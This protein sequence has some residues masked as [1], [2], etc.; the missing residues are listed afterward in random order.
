MLVLAVVI[1]AAGIRLKTGIPGLR[2]VHR[3]AASLE[4]VVVLWLAWMA[5]RRPAVLLALALT[6]I[7]SIVGIIGGQEPPRAIA[8]VNLLGGLSLASVFAWMLAEKGSGPFSEKRVLTPFLVLLVFQILL[9]AWLT[10][11]QRTGAVL[12]AHGLFAMVLMALV[13]FLGLRKRLPLAALVT[14]LA[15]FTALHYEYSPAAALV[16]AVAAAL[17][18]AVSAY[19][20]SRG[21]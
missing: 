18:V 13:I 19:T 1:A 12:P 9:G 11:V 15:G 7:L 4:V 21:A 16:H 17:L 2:I 20:L 6:A 5:W 10:I 14:V 8:A 3:V